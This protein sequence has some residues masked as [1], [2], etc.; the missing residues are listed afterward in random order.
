MTALPSPVRRMPR[1]PQSLLA[2][3]SR[4]AAIALLTFLVALSAR[5]EPTA[6]WPVVAADDAVTAE[7]G[8]PALAGAEPFVRLAAGDVAEEAAADG[9]DE[10]GLAVT[11]PVVVDGD[12][13][14]AE[15]YPHPV[16]FLTVV[17]AGVPMPL[18]F[19]DVS[20]VGAVNGRT[21]LLLHG[22]DLAGD[23]WS[24]T[25]AALSEAGYRVLVPDQVGHGQSGRPAAAVPTA[26]LAA[27]ARVLLDSLGAPRVAVVGHGLAQGTH[28]LCHACRM[29]VNEADRAS[30]T[31]EEG[32]SCPACHA[33]L[34]EQKRTSARERH[35]QE[36]LAAARGTA[37]VGASMSP[38]SADVHGDELTKLK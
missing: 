14:V 22:R 8:E 36:R 28:T 26:T 23:S 16:D 10:I 27:H 3:R 25:I 20:P 29:P 9:A 33:T 2:P 24:T 32:V 15:G 13:D 38:R 17:V 4:P 18:A 6:E 5:Q 37:H 30:P 12:A 19:M 35:R 1:P 34:S 11:E 7:T 21:V 31:Y